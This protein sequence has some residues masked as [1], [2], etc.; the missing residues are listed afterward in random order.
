[1][2]SFRL[3]KNDAGDYDLL[4]E[5]GTVPLVEDGTQAAQHAMERILVFKGELSLD[6]M[7][8]TKTEGGT[9]WYEIIFATDVTKA[10][11]EFHIKKRI[12][13]TTGIKKL[14]SLTWSV[15]DHV[16]S[17]N[18]RYQTNWGEEDISEDVT[19]L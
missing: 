11:K 16:L 18:G 17:I 19:P 3:T 9:Q 7:L 2:K 4:M 6:G 15:E 1:M 14:L 8:T 12:L 10:E 5:N 13:Q